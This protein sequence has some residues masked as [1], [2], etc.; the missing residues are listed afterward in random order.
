MD[1][2]YS[3]DAKLYEKD[4]QMYFNGTNLQVD[5]TIEGLSMNLKDV[6]G[7]KILGELRSG[8]SQMRLELYSVY[9][10][11]PQGKLPTA[12]WTPI[13][14]PFMPLW[15]LSSRRKSGR[16]WKSDSLSS[17]NWYQLITSCPIYQ[18]RHRRANEISVLRN[19][20][21]IVVTFLIYV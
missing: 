4:S 8:G 6:F 18:A 17:W 9:S 2:K 11:N 20:F 10:I 21:Y 14:S 7:I 19:S 13:G 5:Y 12:S 1:V 16:C 15:N 3:M